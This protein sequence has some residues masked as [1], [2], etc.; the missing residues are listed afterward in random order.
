MLIGNAAT[1]PGT[2]FL[3]TTDAQALVFK[4]NA[5]ER[6]RIT[7]DGKVG[8]GTS[9]PQ[10]ALTVVGTTSA[11]VDV[12]GLRYGGIFTATNTSPTSIG[13]LVTAS[14]YGVKASINTASGGTG[15]Y[16]ESQNGSG[17]FGN[18]QNGHA[19]HGDSQNGSAVFGT[20]QN[21]FAM[22]A[23][24][25][26]KQTRTKGGWI[27]AMARIGGNSPYVGA[28]FNSQINP[29]ASPPIANCGI[30]VTKNGTGDYS[31]NFGFQVT[32]RLVSITP[33]FAASGAIIPTFYFDTT[34]DNNTVRVRTYS[35]GTT[36]VDSAF[37]IVVY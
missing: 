37:H 35:G 14:E 9:N 33:E 8:I 30:T 20:S 17:V 10:S 16:G 6:A 11:G 23:D 15:V 32:D 34:S 18:S 22:N 31:V 26:T 36:L 1:T 4:T 19:V 29:L 24:G 3:G 2:N 21:A 25:N 7:S 13:L 12:K 27:K 5:T 28:C